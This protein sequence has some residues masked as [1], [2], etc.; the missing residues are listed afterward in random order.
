MRDNRHPKQRSSAVA[1]NDDVVEQP[2]SK[3]SLSSRH[4]TSTCH[5]L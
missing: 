1:A 5:S 2:F 3:N 4:A